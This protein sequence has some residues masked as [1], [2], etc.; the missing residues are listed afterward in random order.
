MD[1]CFRNPAVSGNF[2]RLAWLYQR[3]I[4]DQPALST[5]GACICFQSA[6]HFLNRKM[7]CCTCDSSHLFLL[8]SFC[9]DTS[10]FL[11]YHRSRIGMI[12]SSLSVLE[13]LYWEG[14]V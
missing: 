11:F 4:D 6:L 5:P 9:L 10:P 14:I 12:E 1:R 7:C 2:F 3:I 13:G 8:L